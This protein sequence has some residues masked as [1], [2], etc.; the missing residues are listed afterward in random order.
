MQDLKKARKK[1]IDC[2]KSIRVSE[3]SVYYYPL[4]DRTDLCIH[5]LFYMVLM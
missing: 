4:T 5:A 3:E 2:S 1:K